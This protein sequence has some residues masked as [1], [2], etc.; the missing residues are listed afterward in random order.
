MVVKGI[1]PLISYVLA[2]L[3]A[4]VIIA[5]IAALGFNFFDAISE[6][7]IRR[8]LSQ[9]AT[10]ASSRITEIYAVSKASSNSPDNSTAVL[11]AESQLNLPSQVS[12]R[13]Y[14]ITLLS[15]GQVATIVSNVS[16]GSGNASSQNQPQTG[17]VVLETTEEP[18]IT[19]EHPLPSIDVDLQGFSGDPE[20]A[21]LR[22]YRYNPNGT[23]IDVIVVGEFSL[24]TQAIGVS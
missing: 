11:L 22:Y 23:V 4:V 15:P 18:I 14:K 2:T 7:Q 5:A 3:I 12:T 6:D 19:V 1:S 13:D 9:I 21:T 20:N 16:Q 8:D 10:Q 24:I 17:M